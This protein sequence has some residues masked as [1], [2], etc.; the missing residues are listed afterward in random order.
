MAISFFSKA[1]TK[2]DNSYRNF[3]FIISL[4]FHSLSLPFRDL[5]SN[6]SNLGLG[7]GTEFS[8][9]NSQNWVQQFQISWYRNRNLGNGFL[10]ITEAVWRPTIAGGFFSELKAGIGYSYLF[11]PIQTYRQ[12]NGNWVRSGHGGK[13][14][15]SIPVAVSGGYSVYSSGTYISPFIGYQFLLLEGYNKSIPIV[16]ETILEIGTGVHLK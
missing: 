9:N 13:G 11:H 14:M 4:Q 2:T 10:L 7:L 8:Y 15:I 6:F 12:E 1:Q 16:P 3:P 5:K